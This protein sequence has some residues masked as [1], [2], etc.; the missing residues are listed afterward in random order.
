MIDHK[1]LD[2]PRKISS[3]T[4]E[5]FT[6]L[7]WKIIKPPR[8]IVREKVKKGGDMGKVQGQRI[9]GEKGVADYLGLH[10]STV[11]RLGKG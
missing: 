6:E 3:K 10:Y 4:R 2:I 8:T 9:L 7:L 1:V 5:K 11:S